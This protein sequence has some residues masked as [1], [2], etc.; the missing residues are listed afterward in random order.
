MSVPPLLARKAL[1]RICETGALEE[2]EGDLEEAFHRWIGSKG[3]SFARR[4]Y[5]REVLC[6]A[7]WRVARSVRRVREG[8]A[9]PVAGPP[10]PLKGGGGS[11][12]RDFLSDVRFALRRLSRTPVSSGIAILLLAVGIG[13]N[14]TIFSVV[15]QVLRK[16]PPLIQE[17]HQLVGIDWVMDGREGPDFGYYDFE[18]Y[19]ENG[20]AFADVLAYGGFTGPRGRRTDGGGGEVAV[21]V[22][23]Q[24]SQAGGWVVSGNYFR[25]LGV[26]MG[27]GPG[28]SSEVR[29]HGEDIREVVISHGYWER[30]FGGDRS[31]VGEPIHLN[32]LPFQVVGVTPEAFRGVNRGEPV[33]DLFIPILSAEAL[34]PG[35]SQELRRFGE[36][37][38]PNAARFLRLVARLRPGIDPAAAQAET[39]VLQARWEAEFTSWAETV[40]GQPYQVRIRP[41]FDMASFESR[42][43]KRQLFFLWFIVG[44]VFLIGCGNLV[45]LLLAKSADRER[46]MG[47]RS[48]L[49]A[50]RRRVTLQL[51]TES[52]VLAILGGVVGLGLA[53]LASGAV[54]ATL[55]MNL[56]DRFTPDGA[57]I[58]FTF[59]LSTLAAILFG[60]VPAWKL[61]RVDVAALIQRPGHGRTRALFRGGLVAFQTALSVLI[62]IVGGLLT[63]SMQAAQEVDLGFD[64]ENRLIMGVVLDNYGYGEEEGR[65]FVSA[66]LDRL[67]DVPGVRDVS[68]MNRIPFLGSNT[69]TF[70]APGTDYAEDGLNIRFNVVGPNYFETMGTDILAGRGFTPD[71][72]PSGGR[73]AIVSQPFA[74]RVW[75]GESPLGKALDFG[76]ELLTVVGVAESSVSASVTESPRAFVYVPSL[77]YLTSRQNFLI[78]AEGSAAALIQPV[79]AALRELNPSLAI[80]PILLS[81]LVDQQ[82]ASFRIWSALVLAIAVAAIF[83]AL[84]GLYGVQASLVSRRTREIG[85]QMALG[86]EASVVVS[87]VVKSGLVMGGLGVLVGVGV[88]LALSGLIRAILFGVSPT[89][90]LVLVSMPALLLAAC[91]VASLIPALR[92]CRINP[93][94]ALRQD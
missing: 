90:P 14:A 28:F 27:L 20:E 44:A 39:S 80:S 31:V 67:R 2:A 63:R 88:A 51:I 74:E 58:L 33:P 43:L 11:W 94:E 29:A 85:V 30:Q 7:F 61:S 93:V 60:T 76:D 21:G 1:R 65:A 91:F 4:R 49:G 66:A 5:W 84:V 47:I 57:A 24:V 55:S 64:P 62:L 25:L 73:V 81:E 38:S 8:P 50:G 32:G 89:D 45:L 36:D 3:L 10:P 59:L 69:W 26:S 41:E 37:G 35:Y 34:S 86:A 56:Q 68:V 6:L 12:G 71:D 13:G 77:T 52:L 53:F 92:A 83:L 79:D 22:G 82:L 18:F 87:Q 54:G 78:A 48:S 9:A 70:T 42:L 72:G 16:A 15:D 75:P 19:R 46:E 17:P 23:D 40:Y